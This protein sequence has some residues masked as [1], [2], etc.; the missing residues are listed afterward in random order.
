LLATGTPQTIV[1]SAVAI[2]NTLLPSSA[3]QTVL[4]GAFSLVN[5]FPTQSGPQ[6]QL[7]AAFSVSNV[8]P[9]GL[10]SQQAGSALQQLGELRNV[11]LSVSIDAPIDGQALVEGQTIVVQAT[12]LGSRGNAEVT[13]TVNGERFGVS[14]RDAA[15]VATSA[16]VT[17]SADRDPST[18]ISG[19]VIDS[20]GNPIGGAVIELLSEG[21]EAE[22][23]DA[24]TSLRGLPDLNGVVPTRA[25]RVT[26]VNVLGPNGVFGLDPFGLA[27]TPDYAA[28]FTG[29]I[30]ISA[31]G[32]YT[33]FLGADEGARLRLSGA[34]V[35]DIASTAGG[36]LERS[37]TVNLGVGLVPIEVTFYEGTG[38]AQLQ[39]SFAPPGGE[40][41]VVPPSALVPNPLSFTVVTDEAGRFT[42][43]GV[44]TAL[45]AVR[46]RATA[47]RSG[48]STSTTSPPIAPVSIG[49]LKVGDIVVVI[50]R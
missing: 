31:P 27:F 15:G 11:S 33:F 45:E 50:S 44:P 10:T 43:R 29:W 41:R 14:V 25:T 49:G 24:T 30:A 7:S 19:R 48:L 3:P 2:L 4:S 37:A 26:A 42:I 38:N 23:F 9:L 1:S 17:V 22:F 6:S 34:T 46:V 18:T 28:R 12:V 16:P 8:D 39:L 36:F 20:D 35:I 47:T 5:A 40:R 13:F 32:A 21:L